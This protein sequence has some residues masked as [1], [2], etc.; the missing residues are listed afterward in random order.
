M[1]AFGFWRLLA[2]GG[3]WLLVAFGFRS[4]LAFSGFGLFGGFWLSVVF[5]F[6]W[7][8]AFGGLHRDRAAVDRAVDLALTLLSGAQGPGPRAR[9]PIGP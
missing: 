8:S 7:L 3:F 4:L 9:D 6:Q 1:V 5:G 2:F